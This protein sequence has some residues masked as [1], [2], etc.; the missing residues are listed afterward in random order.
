MQETKKAVKQISVFFYKANQQEKSH[1]STVQ[2]IWAE[3]SQKQYR[4][5]INM[6]KNAR[7]VTTI[8]KTK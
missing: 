6:E 3:K 1:P 2:R 4:W 8:R 5:L 7:S